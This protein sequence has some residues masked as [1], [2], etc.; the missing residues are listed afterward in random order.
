MKLRLCQWYG[1]ART[2]RR[3]GGVK[4]GPK[5]PAPTDR[6]WT[7]DGKPPE[8]ACAIG[9]GL[10][11]NVDM[12]NAARNLYDHKSTMSACRRK[13]DQREARR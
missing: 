8:K 7:P 12:S 6:G 10:E 9:L 5:N 1:W 11:L 3:A 2:E 4:G 13:G